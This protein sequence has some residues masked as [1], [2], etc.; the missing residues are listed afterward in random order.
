MVFEGSRRFTFQRRGGLSRKLPAL[1]GK[2]FPAA[3]ATQG[4]FIKT[5]AKDP[6]ISRDVS[7][8]EYPL[9]AQRLLARDLKEF[10]SVSFSRWPKI[11]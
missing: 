1:A 8:F 6:A 5:G 4:R 10:L 9:S 3:T 2:I 11:G 7:P